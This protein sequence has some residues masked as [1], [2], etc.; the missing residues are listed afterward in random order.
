MKKII[1][2]LILSLLIFPLIADAAVHYTVITWNSSADAGA[3]YD[4]YKA[5]GVCPATGIP[6]GAV[7]I[8][9]GLNVLTYTDSSPTLVAGQ[10]NC[11]Y[12]IAKLN[13]VSSSPSNTSIAITPVGNPS[14]CKAVGY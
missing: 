4:V 11:Y 2:I 9:T 10:T 7:T 13:G 6:T 8:A 5:P 1:Q 12:V 14:S 3:T